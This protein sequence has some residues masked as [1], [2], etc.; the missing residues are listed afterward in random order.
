MPAH[1]GLLILDT[2]YS[3]LHQQIKTW[4]YIYNKK[5]I[6]EADGGTVDAAVR[7][8]KKGSV[9]DL[10][11][12]REAQSWQVYW[13]LNKSTLKPLVKADWKAHLADETKNAKGSWVGF[14]T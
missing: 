2:I 9:L 12:K 14:L 3:P 10:S 11:T 13:A 1:S 5:F 4:Y 8:T 6:K 7:S